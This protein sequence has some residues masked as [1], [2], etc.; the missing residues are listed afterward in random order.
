MRTD[1]NSRTTTRPLQ[2]LVRGERMASFGVM[3][4]LFGVFAL[5]IGSLSLTLLYRAEQ[6]ST[7]SELSGLKQT[8]Y[9]RCLQRNGYDE[10][11]HNSVAA[12][13]VLFEEILKLSR[14]VPPSPDAR[15]RLLQAQYREAIVRAV[16]EKRAAATQGVI[17]V[18]KVYR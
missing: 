11:N 15:E 9:E 16:S 7:K 18:C 17:G 8:I 10:A 12:D 3:L 13:V 5:L 1:P 4:G 6:A 2:S 14:L